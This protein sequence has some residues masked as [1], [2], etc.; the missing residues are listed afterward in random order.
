MLYLVTG[1]SGSGKS[2]Y[3]EQL[4]EKLYEEAEASV[5]EGNGNKKIYIATMIPR[6]EETKQKIEK[7]RRMRREKK[8]E[9]VECYMDLDSV[10]REEAFA[11]DNREKFVLLECMSNLVA[12]EMFEDPSGQDADK[13]SVADKIMRGVQRLEEKCR[14]VVVVTNE[15]CT[16]S[17]QDLPEMRLYKKNLSEINRRLAG[18]AEEVTEVVYGI[19]CRHRTQKT[20]KT[21]K[22]DRLPGTEKKS[23]E[24][25]KIERK[26]RLG[27]RLIIGGAY[28]GKLTYAKKA[29]PDIKEWTDGAAC[30]L[31]ALLSCEGMYHFEEYIKRMLSG[32]FSRQTFMQKSGQKESQELCM[33]TSQTSGEALILDMLRRN[34]EVVLISR[35]I[36]YGLVPVDAFERQYRETTGRI[37]TRI[38][39]EAS[40]VDRVICGIVQTIKKTDL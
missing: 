5:D 14:A 18:R 3:A 23:E 6:G 16:E 27:M 24:T 26:E 19:S 33:G 28:Q 10:Y 36:G 1:G 8:F 31:E 38:A 4:I 37:C 29:Y 7:H 15:V 34:P 20:E 35:E 25:E 12:N 40:R 11:E 22:S 17:A 21:G 30:P 2:E 32:A 13:G 39:A 9:T